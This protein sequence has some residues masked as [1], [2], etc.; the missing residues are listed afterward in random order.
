MED[1]LKQGEQKLETDKRNVADT[2]F[3]L[4]QSRYEQG[5]YRG[6]VVAFQECLQLRPDDPVVL[7][8]LAESLEGSGD[9]DGAETASRSSLAINE[10]ALGP[11]SPEVATNLNNLAALTI[12]RGDYTGAEPL[13]R[14]ALRIKEEA[15]GP[16]NP[17]VATALNNVAQLLQDKGD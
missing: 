9:F 11:N 3:F 6:S 12:A 15:L 1:S 13:L 4:G 5:N 14:R 7:N 16:D 2:A 10:K 17:E 8:N